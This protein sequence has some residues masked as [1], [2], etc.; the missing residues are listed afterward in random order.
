LELIEVDSSDSE[1]YY[2]NPSASD[3]DT[4]NQS[5]T[6]TYKRK[7]PGPFYCLITTLIFFFLIQDQLLKART[8]MNERI[9]SGKSSKTSQNLLD[10]DVSSPAA[11]LS[12]SKSPI[13]TSPFNFSSRP[14]S[15]TTTK[16]RMSL[17]L[18]SLLVY[19]AGVKFRGLN[20]KM[21]PVNTF[22]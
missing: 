2:T 9:R 14:P 19:T 5:E 21:H 7:V 18:L 10:L 11:D 6:T 12:D 13:P 15:A 8:S 3:S 17:V 22:L 20:N 1:G 4:F 16:L